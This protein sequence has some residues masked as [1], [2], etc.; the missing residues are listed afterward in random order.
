MYPNN[1]TEEDIRRRLSEKAGQIHPPS[2]PLRFAY[3]PQLLRRKLKPASVLVPFL[4][5]D[6]AW[7][8]LLTRRK[9]TLVEHS[10]Q[11]AFPG[12][13]AE[14][15]DR[16][17]EETALRE[18]REEIGLDPGSVHILGRLDSFVTITNYIL[19]PVVGHIP[20]PFPLR[21]EEEEVQRVFTV[22]LTWLVDPANHEVR[23]RILPAPFPS[24][25]VIYFHPYDGEILWG[26]SAQVTV[27]LLEFLF[28][29][30]SGKGDIG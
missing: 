4:Q 9:D 27:N 18:A 10:G 26:V 14:P 11:V 7:N 6:G 1:L 21:L 2:D 20:W 17:L 28:E 30:E 8:I 24:L 19:T 13:R 22:P 23:P 5:I 3:P 12:G 29:G 25:P 16:S 15:G